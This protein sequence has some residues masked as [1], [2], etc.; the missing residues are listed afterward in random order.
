MRADPRPLRVLVVDDY[1]D[2][3]SSCAELLGYYG[4]ET[5]ATRC[6]G[7][8]LAACFTW[9][10][11]VVLLD[12]WLPGADGF[13]VARQVRARNGSAI[14]LVAVTAISTREYRERATAAGFDH[15][16]VK[17]TEPAVLVDLLRSLASADA[18]VT[19]HPA[20]TLAGV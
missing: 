2:V 8:A 14:C 16:L 5:R 12:L 9:R 20:R 13:E 19:G 11:D 4:F 3:A 10:P 6:G 15:F 17:P 1:P 7:V 18:S